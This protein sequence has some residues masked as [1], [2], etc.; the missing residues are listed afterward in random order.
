MLKYMLIKHKKNFKC[1]SCFWK[2]FLFWKFSKISK[3]VQPCSGDLPRS[4]AS[5]MPQLRAYTEGF[6]DSLAG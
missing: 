4:Q 6:H 1:F 5:R 2:V 3:T